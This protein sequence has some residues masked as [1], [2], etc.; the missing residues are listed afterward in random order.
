LPEQALESTV[1]GLVATFED[2]WTTC[3]SR[4]Q[5]AHQSQRWDWTKQ[6]RRLLDEHQLDAAALIEVITALK[7]YRDEMDHTRYFDPRDLHRD[8]TEWEVVRSRLLICR[9][10]EGR[11]RS[12]P[13]APTSVTWFEEDE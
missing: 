12:K 4:G 5:E 10:Q 13:A 8:A 1:S 6:F 2:F 7:T 9:L 11:N 3:F